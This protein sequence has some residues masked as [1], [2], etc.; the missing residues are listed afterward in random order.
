MAAPRDD[1][2]KRM[3]DMQKRFYQGGAGPTGPVPTKPRPNQVPSRNQTG[4]GPVR[5]AARVQSSY[6]ST[7]EPEYVSFKTNPEL[8]SKQAAIINAARA[9][10][11]QARLTGEQDARGTLD[12]VY[13]SG[14]NARQSVRQAGVNQ[15]NLRAMQEAGLNQRQG[16][17]FAQRLTE[18]GLNRADAVADQNRLRGLAVRDQAVSAAMS[19]YEKTG[20]PSALTEVMKGYNQYGVDGPEFNPEDVNAPAFNPKGSISMGNAVTMPDGTKISVRYDNRTGEY[21]DAAT[22]KMISD[23]QK[24]AL[25]L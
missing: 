16:N 13:Q 14:L 10:G 2:K 6:R 24:Q 11:H 4:V 18:R 21:V 1:V 3:M 19:L 8:S 17:E 22:G 5:P 7:P 15:R 25:G 20:D 12:N 9:K 23:Y